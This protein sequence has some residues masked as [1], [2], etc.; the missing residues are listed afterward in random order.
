[1]S[2]AL[3]EAV[4]VSVVPD[5]RSP[6]VR[7][8]DRL[9]ALVDLAERS[10]KIEA[11]QASVRVGGVIHEAVRFALDNAESFTS[12]RLSV[13]RRRELARRSVVAE[14]ATRCGFPSSR[15]HAWSMKRTRC[16][17]DFRRHSPRCSTVRSITRTP[18]SW[19]TRPTTWRR[20]SDPVSARCGTRISCCFRDARDASTGRTRAS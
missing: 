10:R 11:M 2:I 12:P 6:S 13:S 7:A 16:A 17:A 5:V 3:A 19:S 18:G 20:R 1:M 15:W 8:Q 14:L 9:D 4:S